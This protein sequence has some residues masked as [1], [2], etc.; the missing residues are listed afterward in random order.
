M[1]AMSLDQPTIP[2]CSV[3]TCGGPR[4]GKK[5]MVGHEFWLSATSTTTCH[6]PSSAGWDVLAVPANEL[7]ELDNLPRYLLREVVA[8]WWYD[9]EPVL[10]LATQSACESEWFNSALGFTD[11]NA[12]FRN[13]QSILTTVTSVTK[14]PDCYW[15]RINPRFTISRRHRNRRVR[16]PL[17]VSFPSLSLDCP[18]AS[19][20]I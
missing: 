14:L 4:L 7:R 3:P 9:M 15:T 13:R 11:Q 2:P 1:N 6:A 20:S 18:R 19:G 12:A 5:K 16:S 10:V 8:L 17:T